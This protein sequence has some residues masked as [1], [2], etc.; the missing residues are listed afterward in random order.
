[1][2]T[3]SQRMVYVCQ[4]QIEDDNAMCGQIFD[5]REVSCLVLIHRAFVY[6]HVL[7]GSKNSYRKGRSYS[8]VLISHS[9]TSSLRAGLSTVYQ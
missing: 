1:M 5:R 8:K 2:D 4:W 7:P 6:S 3:G 9:I